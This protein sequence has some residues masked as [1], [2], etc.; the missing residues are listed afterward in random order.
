MEKAIILDKKITKIAH[1][2]R[3]SYTSINDKK[4]QKWLL[5]KLKETI[6]ERLN[7][8]KR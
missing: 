4:D 1:L 6:E 7:L 8:I 2:L 5:N 3:Y